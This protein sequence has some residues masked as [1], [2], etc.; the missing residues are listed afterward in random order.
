[1]HVLDEPVNELNEGKLVIRLQGTG[2]T[3]E[4]HVLSVS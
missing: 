3:A 2:A 4:G 1:M